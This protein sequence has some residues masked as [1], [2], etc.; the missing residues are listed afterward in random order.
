M[1]HQLDP[2][3]LDFKEEIQSTAKPIYRPGYVQ[4]ELVCLHEADL[5][6]K[7]QIITN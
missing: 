3:I 2:Q 6:N 5:S 7:Q 4:A 1:G